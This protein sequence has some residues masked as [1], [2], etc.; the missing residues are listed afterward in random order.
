MKWLLAG[1]LIANARNGGFSVA[2]QAPPPSMGRLQS[3]ESRI[4]GLQKRAQNKKDMVMVNC[5]SDK[6]LQVR[7]YI[8]VG[9]AALSGIEAAI[10]QHDAVTRSHNFDRQTIVY[11]KVL[12]LGT[13][14]E[15]CIG[16]DVNYVGATRVDIE[17]DPSIPQEDPTIPPIAVGNGTISDGR[18]SCSCPNSFPSESVSLLACLAPSAFSPARRLRWQPY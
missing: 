18:L 6:L 10:Q 8:S 11:Q 5:A 7:G 16:E 4:T 14:A 17:I 15:G 12:V 13:E 3:V 2:D 9:N 1:G